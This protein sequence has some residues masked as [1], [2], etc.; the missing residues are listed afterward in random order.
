MAAYQTIT[1]NMDSNGLLVWER[2]SERVEVMIEKKIDPFR[3]GVERLTGKKQYKPTPGEYF[4][5]KLRLIGGEWPTQKE[6][7]EAQL[8]DLE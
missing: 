4:V 7:I 2:D 8:E 5:P 6:M 1:D 3:A